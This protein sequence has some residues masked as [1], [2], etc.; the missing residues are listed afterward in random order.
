MDIEYYCTVL[1]IRVMILK[2]NLPA[3]LLLV[4]KQGMEEVC[5][6]LILMVAL[7]LKILVVLDEIYTPHRVLD[8]S[9]FVHR[10]DPQTFFLASGNWKIL[11]TMSQVVAAKPE[12]DLQMA[13]L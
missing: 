10:K 4:D 8:F 1:T 7:H 12:L 2:V 13:R 5:H 3:R 9:I 11:Y 6:P